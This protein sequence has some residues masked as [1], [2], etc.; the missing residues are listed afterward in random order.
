[1]NSKLKLGLSFV[2]GGIIF[3]APF[4]ISNST[5]TEDVLVN[6]MAGAMQK[7]SDYQQQ[8]EDDQLAKL[9]NI[10]DCQNMEWM[11]NCSEINKQGKKHPNAPLRV[12]SAS[13]V[14]FNFVPGTPS[15]VIRLQLE[16][17]PAAAMAAVLYNDATW[18]EYK[19]SASLTKNATWE[20]GP[21]ANV[22]GLDRAKAIADAP[23]QINTKSIA[24]SVFVH[25]MC[26]ACEVQLSTLGKLQE[27]YPDLKIT[28]FQ[29][30]ENADGFKTKVTDNGLKGRMLNPLEAR[31]ALKAGID[32]WPTTWIDNMP[33]KQRETLAG[34]KSIVQL[35]DRLQGITHVITAKK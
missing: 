18:G 2:A 33:M 10:M 6:A 8:K 15:A 11:K 20:A 4:A 27:R 14:E 13:G 3:N 5:S 24:I 32:K 25:S 22:I 34:V 19:K 35:E 26:G 17:T 31:N 1:M 21:L 9:P 12:V 16:Q 28:V 29:F 30:D 7:V 23:K